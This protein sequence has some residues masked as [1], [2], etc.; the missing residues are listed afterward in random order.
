M[1]NNL[2]SVVN[3]IEGVLKPSLRYI[4]N[5]VLYTQSIIGDYKFCARSEDYLGWLLCDGR[6]LSRTEYPA[7][8]EIIGTAFGNTDSTN[9]RLPDLRGRVFGGIG[10][11][12]GLTNRT[13]GAVVGS[14]TH[15]L[16]VAQIPSHDHGGSTSVNGS[17]THTHNANGGNTGLAFINGA[18]TPTTTDNSAGELNLGAT[19]TLTINANGDHSHTISAQG[20]G[21]AHNNMQP[22]L[23]CGNMMIFGGLPGDVPGI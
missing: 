14:E 8:F 9:F 11:G 22:T 13:L 10:S 21:E 19:G 1:Y 23:F 16:T 12:S 17:H 4:G 2:T 7:L 3:E 15:T 6:L 18:N 20:G 5:T